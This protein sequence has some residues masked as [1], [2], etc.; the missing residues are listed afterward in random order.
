MYKELTDKIKYSEL[1]REILKFWKENKIFEKSIKTRE[2]K[3]N[4][5][6]YEGPPT[7]NGRPGIH[8]VMSRTIKDLVCRYKTMRGFKV[9]RKAGWDTHGLP[10]EI[11]IEKKLGIKHKDEIIEYGIEKFN[12]ECK[13]SVFE[14][15][16]DWEEM[17]ERIGYWIDLENAYITF[18]NEY[19]ESIWWALKQFFDKGYI[20]KG[21]KIQPY[22]PRC[23]TPL[24]SHEVAQGY[25]DV[26]DPSIYVKVKAKDE[27]KNLF[28]CLDNYSMDIDLKCCTCGSPR[29]NLC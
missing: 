29:S 25:E 19:I 10:V 13:K 17:T 2:G 14:Y 6:F 28:P 9:Y 7:A 27:E 20:Y 12:A 3:P 1:E 16:D 18:T 11:E 23:E 22:C 4:F 26:K 8:H 24:S 5:T 21:Y 15:L